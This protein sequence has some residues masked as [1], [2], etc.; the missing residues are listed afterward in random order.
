MRHPAPIKNP[1]FTADKELKDIRLALDLSFG[2]RKGG[3]WS[4]HPDGKRLVGYATTAEKK[5]QFSVCTVNYDGTDFKKISDHDSGGHVSIC[6][7]DY[8]LLLTDESTNPGR[9]VFI[10]LTTD[11]EI[12]SYILPR[13][14]G[15]KEVRG[16]NPMRVCHHPVFSSDGKTVIVNIMS[17]NYAQICEVDTIGRSKE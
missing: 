8:H 15:E 7:T 13:V 9:V 17:G 11:T 6:P 2:R 5:N 16:R 14:N 4:W 3:H 1:Y 10:N 12:G